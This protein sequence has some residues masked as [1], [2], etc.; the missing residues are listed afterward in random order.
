[1]TRMLYTANGLVIERPHLSSFMILLLSG[2]LCFAASNLARWWPGADGRFVSSQTSDSNARLL[3]LHEQDKT[4]KL[5][6]GSVIPSRPRR[7]SLPLIIICVVVR[8]EIFQRVNY[9]QQC[10]TPGIEVSPVSRYHHL[11][12]SDRI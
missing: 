7:Y 12:E 4:I 1:M 5:G 3:R 11:K 9:Q 6:S 10:S 2:G 8:L